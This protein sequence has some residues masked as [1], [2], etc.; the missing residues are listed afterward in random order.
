MRSTVIL[1]E[2]NDLPSSFV[3]VDVL[4]E[5][6]HSVRQPSETKPEFDNTVAFVRA[7]ALH[8]AG[9]Y[10]EAWTELESANRTLHLARKRDA[11]EH[12][13]T[14]RANLAQL[15][16]K[17]INVVGDTSAGTMSLFILGPS[18]SGKTTMETLVGMLSGV[19][20]GYENPSVE[21][22]IRRTFQGAGLLT[23]AMFEVLPPRLDSNCRD[24]YF[25]EL[26]RRAGSAKVFTNTHPVRLHDVARIAAAFP[27]VRF[28]FIKRNLDD[29]MLRIFMRKYAVGNPYAYDLG[30]IRNHILWYQEMIDVLADKLPD[31]TRVIRYEDVVANPTAALTVAADL[32]GLPMSHGPLPPI[33][34][35][36]GCA[37]PYRVLMDEVLTT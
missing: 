37:E 18:R 10:A 16:E 28:V 30:F 35:D 1:N 7:A 6:E 23:T 14:Q 26:A 31:I 2:L 9:R 13:D 8:K 20:R 21:K 5:L 24:I 12:A 3:R 33:G 27:N 29:N 17:R 15:K 4:R 25:E 32:C 19:K 34:D 11:E 22:A 36:R